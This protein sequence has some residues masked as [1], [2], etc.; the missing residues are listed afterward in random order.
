MLCYL[1]PSVAIAT[2][3][4]AVYATSVRAPLA[5]DQLTFV[6]VV[7]AS[8]SP[9]APARPER[10]VVPPASPS[11]PA[12]AQHEPVKFAPLRAQNPPPLSTQP[13]ARAPLAGHRRPNRQ[14]SPSIHELLQSA[15]AAL[16]GYNAPLVRRLLDF[17]TPCKCG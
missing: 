6:P 16:A 17:A 4:V 2:A 1:L 12:P 10:P 7:P 8:P 5:G 13:I 14:L 3:C 11:A 9:P 15:R